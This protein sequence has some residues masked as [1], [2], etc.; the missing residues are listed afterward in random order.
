MY[1]LFVRCADY[2]KVSGLRRKLR[3][4]LRKWSIVA[5]KTGVEWHTGDPL[6]IGTHKDYNQVSGGVFL[7]FPEV[8]VVK[9]R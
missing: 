9:T 4:K 8:P 2:V 6:T 5:I 3:R 7:L 1:W